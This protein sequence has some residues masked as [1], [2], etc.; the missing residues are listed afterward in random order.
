MNGARIDLS[1][2]LDRLPERGDRFLFRIKRLSLDVSGT[3]ERRI[4]EA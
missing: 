1:V 2:G 4:T 3:F